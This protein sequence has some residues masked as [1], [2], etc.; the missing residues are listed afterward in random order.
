MANSQ[1]HHLVAIIRT[2]AYSASH[3]DQTVQPQSQTTARKYSKKNN[4]ENQHLQNDV[5]FY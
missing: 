3:S 4:I 2:A 1:I 5:L